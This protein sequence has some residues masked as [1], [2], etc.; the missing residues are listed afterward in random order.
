VPDSHVVVQLAVEQQLTSHE[1][2]DRLL[3]L[4]RIVAV[5]DRRPDEGRPAQ[6]A[7]FAGHARIE[8]KRRRENFP[9]EVALEG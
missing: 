4:L 6:P 3:R 5:T 9:L 8:E 1:G 2:I 7:P